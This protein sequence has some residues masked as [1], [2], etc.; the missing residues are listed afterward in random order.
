VLSYLQVN[1]K[2]HANW[3][4]VIRNKAVKR[5][6]TRIKRTY[7]IG[8]VYGRLTVTGYARLANG[9][10]AV[11]C[12]CACGKQKAVRYPNQ[13]RRRLVSSCG[14]L[15]REKAAARWKGKPAAGRLAK[16]EAA[17]RILLRVYR[18]NALLR[19]FGF[20]LDVDAFQKLTKSECYYCGAPPS[21]V[22]GRDKHNGKYVYNGID[23]VDS[24]EGYTVKNSVPCCKQ[25]NRAK[26]NLT[27]VA[28]VCW[29]K[30]VAAKWAAHC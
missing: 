17:F 4:N 6:G 30:R 14:C 28:F 19:G 26:R 10:W 22:S 1:A 24:N 5:F 25:C 8:T 3:L 20:E 2:D 18:R 9:C 11:I 15:S 13:M 12:Q 16:G 23:R 21:A 27:H 7:P 29:I